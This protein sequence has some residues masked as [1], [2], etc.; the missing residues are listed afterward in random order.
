MTKLLDCPFGHILCIGR[1]EI[2][3]IIL[4]AAAKNLTPVT[5][6]LGGKNPVIVS[7]KANI[8]L[9]AKRIA[10]SKHYGAGQ[11]C[12]T[13]DYALVQESICRVQL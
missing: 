13:P 12:I 2:G 7:E 3:K 1:A 5:L 11:L 9:A 6:E 10:W 8:A 4:T